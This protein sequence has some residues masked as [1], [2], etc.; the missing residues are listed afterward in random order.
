MP[1]YINY[2]NDN[3][4]DGSENFSHYFQNSVWY[5]QKDRFNIEPRYDVLEA[6]SA[7]I[8]TYIYDDCSVR[9]IRALRYLKE[10]DDRGINIGYCAY[11]TK[12]DGCIIAWEKRPDICKEHRC[13]EWINKED[14]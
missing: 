14:K 5:L 6:Y 3:I 8:D 2:S 13:Q 12:E 10:L 7:W 9:K 11:W 1:D 4:L